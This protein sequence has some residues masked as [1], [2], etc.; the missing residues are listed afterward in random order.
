[1][2]DPYV[3][4]PEDDEAP[5]ALLDDFKAYMETAVPGWQPDDAAIEVALGAAW[6]DEGST[7]YSLLRD[8]ADD[9]YAGFGEEV[10]SVPAAEAAP[11]TAET[12]WTARD[13]AGYTIDAGQT[14][15]IGGY[16][17]EVLNETV[18]DPGDTAVSGVLVQA[19]D[20]GTEPNG[21]ED[22]VEFDEPP[23][24]VSSVTVD[25]PAEGGTDG[26]TADEH[27]ARV[28]AE[29]SLL[30]R[31]P[32]NAE[33]FET[34]AQEEDEVARALV[35]DNY[36][37]GANEKQSVTIN[38]TGGTWT[39]SFGGQT[40]AALAWNVTASA[41]QSAIEAL[42]NFNPGDVIV[43]GGPGA[44]AP[45]VVEFTGQYTDTNVA[46][47]TTNAGSLTGGAGTA[48]VA[49]TQAGAAGQEDQDLVVSVYPIDDAGEPVSAGAKTSLAAR[50]AGRVIVNTEVYI[51]DPTYT[52][53][54]VALTVAAGEG[55]SHSDLEDR[56]AA[57]IAGEGLNPATY[58][59]P[60]LGVRTTWKNRPVVRQ[61]E[62]AAIAQRVE[63]VD[64]V[65][66]A[67]LLDGADADL[68]LPGAAPLPRAG[69]I[70]ITVV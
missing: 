29:A 70:T 2:A 45:L 63:G 52:P 6:A 20:P 38:A 44:T 9:I 53:V 17:F 35:R 48:V 55:V 41:F 26:D 47:A 59:L 34:V 60:L 12:T 69:T 14:L 62:I 15:V 31:A 54:D 18:I 21:V 39:W 7:L 33:D 1:M 8:Q 37:P 25:A 50:Y 65:T 49:V 5:E 61:Y 51:G 30:S 58:G 56:V 40:T 32:I 3:R 27:I 46:T 4:L 19:L 68:T 43:T 16:G 22:P 11:A 36:L 64:D 28:R 66:S 23:A 67:V 13:N 10:L 24:W 42:S 57:A